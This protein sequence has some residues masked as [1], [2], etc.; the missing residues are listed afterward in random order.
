MARRRRGV[1][2]LGVATAG[3]TSKIGERRSGV[4]EGPKELISPERFD[5]VTSL[6]E[7]LV[8]ARN[9]ELEMRAGVADGKV[10]LERTDLDGAAH[11]A[12]RRDGRGGGLGAG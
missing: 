12:A 6:V 7:L 8:A 3:E 10:A 11:A 9:T 4:V 2:T 1:Y 5:E